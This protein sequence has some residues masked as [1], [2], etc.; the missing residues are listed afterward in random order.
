MHGAALTLAIQAQALGFIPDL[1]V[2]TE[3]LDLAQFLAYLRKDWGQ[4]PAA[5]Y[6]H[7][8]QLTYPWSQTDPDVGK[9]DNHYAFLNYSTALVADL[10]FFNSEY[11]RQSFLQAL[12]SFLAQFPDFTHPE[13]VEAIR[14]KSEVLPLGLHLGLFNGVAPL[15]AG[16]TPRI[17]WNHRW[18]YDKHPDL[19]FETL[20]QLQQEGHA[21]DLMVM[22][23]HFAKVP[24]VFAKAK[25]QLE[26][27]KGVKILHWGY[28]DSVDQYRGNLVSG[29]ILP[30]TSVHDFFGISVVEG[31][32]AGCAPLLPNRLAY[33]EHIPQDL[34]ATYLYDSDQAFHDRLAEWLV[35]RPDPKACRE[36]V[37][38]KYDWS[39]LLPKYLT[40]FQSLIT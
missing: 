33:P 35:T 5:V 34:Q 30:V 37:N 10:V 27:G 40:A 9:R 15:H 19:F 32:A 18:E 4:V 24:P 12:P 17:V 16:E 31:I 39:T 26:Q 1:I 22:G 2:C 21:F 28:A 3:M 11:H 38:D 6:F 7:E 8:N 25:Q 36:F 13:T 29:S 23:Q 14:L 20:L